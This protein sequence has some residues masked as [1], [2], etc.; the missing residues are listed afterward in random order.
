MTYEMHHMVVEDNTY[1]VVDAQARSDISEINT[2]L[3]VE[4]ARIDG[5]IALPDG[6]TTADAELRDIRVGVNGEVYPSAGDAVRDQLETKIDL[7]YNLTPIEITVQDQWISTQLNEFGGSDTKHASI[8][9]SSGD[10][11]AISGGTRG[12]S[13]N[14]YPAAFCVDA[15]DVPTVLCNEGAAFNEIIVIPDGAVTLYVNNSAEGII[16]ISEGVLATQAQF[17]DKVA[18]SDGKMPNLKFLYSG[19]TVIIKRKYNDEKD[20][21]L[22]IGNTGNNNLINFISLKYIGNT[23]KE[24]S[25]SFFNNTGIQQ[26]TLNGSDWL[27][28]YVVA[29][30]NNID[31]DTPNTTDFTGGNHKTTGGGKT[32]DQQS[33]SVLIN[34]NHEAEQGIIYTCERLVIRWVNLIQAYNTSKT[35]GSGRGVITESWEAVID[36]DRIRLRNK[37]TALEDVTI[38]RYYGFQMTAPANQKYSFIGG[39]N[40]GEYTRM[41]SSGTGEL[42]NSGNNTCRKAVMHNDY[43]AVEVG[44]DPVDLGLFDH[45]GGVSFFPSNGKLYSSLIDESNPLDLDEGD[46]CYLYG[47]YRFY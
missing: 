26:W 45:N 44:V 3:A 20:M 31:G 14:Y 16:N 15:N 46:M 12:S 9:V 21:M 32:A 27:G 33:I 35:D 13:S 29:A 10:I 19:D 42:A 24:P 6:S 2:D 40:R 23:E 41:T 25:N 47:Y 17:A 38:K 39:A 5:I 18:V 43:Y 34:G 7:P 1:E 37:I 22:T 28:P 4:R 36:N 11:Y 30:K 8:S